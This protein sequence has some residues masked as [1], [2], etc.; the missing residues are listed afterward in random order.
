LLF[1]NGSVDLGR[2]AEV[3]DMEV[4]VVGPP[5]QTFWSAWWGGAR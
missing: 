1:A 2:Y 5:K 3:R 4:Q